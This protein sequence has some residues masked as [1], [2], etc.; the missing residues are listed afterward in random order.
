MMLV[1]YRDSK[2]HWTP[3]Q[4]KPKAGA[5]PEQDVFDLYPSPV[6][7]QLTLIPGYCRA[8]TQLQFCQNTA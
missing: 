7:G 4:Q 2:T 8:F 1:E 6:E 5:H 3:H